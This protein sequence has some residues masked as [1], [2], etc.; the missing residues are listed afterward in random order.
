MDAVRLS[1]IIKSFNGVRVLHGVDFDLKRGEVH[2]LLGGNGAGKSTLMKILEGVYQPDEGKI[3]IAGRVID[4]RVRRPAHEL[5]LAMIFQEFSLIPSLSVAK[6]VYLTRES[7]TR[8]GL[9]DDRAS[10]RN[11][12][13]IFREM[14][15][16][17][18]PGATVSQLSTGAWQLTEIA[19]ALSQN[20]QVL[21]MDEPTASLTSAE[22]ES[23]FAIIRGLKA[24][25]I[26]II[27]I[28]H[29]MEEIFQIADRVTVLRDGHNVATK[30]VHEVSVVELIEM[31]IGKGV[32][33][34]LEYQGRSVN[35]E[36]EPLL[37]LRGLTAPPKV[38][39]VSLK[40]F[41]GEILGI[42]GLMGSGRSELARALFGVDQ[43]ASGQ[44]LINGRPLSITHPESAIRAGICLIPEDR[45]TQGLV[46]DHSVRDNT[47]LPLLDRMRNGWFLD[48]RRVD[49]LSNELVTRLNIR[50]E[51]IHKLVK[52]LSGGN[53]QKVVLAK[54]LAAKTKVL[55]MDEPTVGVDIGAKAEI[56][57][58][59]RELAETGNGIIVISSEIPIL[60][61]TSDRIAVMRDGEIEVIMPRQ[62]I[63]G[64]KELQHILHQGSRHGR[65]AA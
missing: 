2:A 18:D 38:R 41:S 4:S 63:N 12:A 3:E 19:K 44:V 54:W 50:T 52:L 1:G 26:S 5:G 28:S 62:E 35:R 46:L 61:A 49:A 39:T 21:I 65:L 37:E 20:A 64:E 34:A 27:Y 55:I 32:E 11:A 29:R 15:V 7:R 30:S 47:V 23:L 22:V 57:T 14:G 40:L 17:I 48:D 10:E 36:V 25:G 42:A 43:I 51:S 9:L 16:D 60:L 58:I 56:I 31:I 6:N 24:Q 53:Q 13:A 33:S 45:R 8:L 59:I